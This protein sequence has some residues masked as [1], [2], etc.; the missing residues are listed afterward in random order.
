M[1]KTRKDLLEGDDDLSLRVN[2]KFAEKY[3]QKKRHEELSRAK[4]L[5]LLDDDESTSEEEDEE[6][7][8]LTAQVDNKI[9]ETLHMIKKKDPKI[10][11]KEISFFTDEDFENRPNADVKKEKPLKY[12][13]Y[14][15]ETLLE[16]G[17]EALESD[18]EKPS[19]REETYVE[20]QA[21]LKQEFLKAFDSADVSENEHGTENGEPKKKKKDKKKKSKRGKDGDADDG[22][23]LRVRS[24]TKEEMEREDEDFSE[25]IKKE[26]IKAKKEAV[27]EMQ[28]LQRYFEDEAGLDD[29]EKFL[30]DYILN[31]GWV[32]RNDPTRD[33]FEEDGEEVDD[34]ED[35]T[36]LEATDE[37]EASYNFRFQ[38]EGGDQIIGHSRNLEG[39]VRKKDDK[40]QKARLERE[41]RKQE[42]KARKDEELKRLKN[43]KKKEIAEKIKKIQEIT[44]NSSVGLDAVDIEGDFDPAEHDA[45]MS[46]MFDDSYYDQDDDGKPAFDDDDDILTEQDLS[47]IGAL[48]GKK[49]PASTAAVQEQPES[50]EDYFVCDG[51]QC[52]LLPIEE[53]FDCR[54]CEDYCLCPTCKA[55]NKHSHKMKRIK[56]SAPT[57]SMSDYLDEYYK[58][59]YEDIIG[60]LPVR[61]KYQ[62]VAANHYGL[63]DEELL[64]LDDKQLNQ[65]VPLKKLAP[66][67]EDQGKVASALLRK[68]KAALLSVDES[69]QG[70][71]T[72][73][74]HS[75]HEAEGSS[76]HEK[77]HKKNR[78]DANT[79]PQ[80]TGK[81]FKDPNMRMTPMGVT[82]SR[83]E[84]YGAA[85]KQVMRESKRDKYRKK[86]QNGGRC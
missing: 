59:D 30:R 62:K 63:T 64:A 39:S 6:G 13:D 44:G 66:Y 29:N 51:C 33:G 82:E 61:F 57:M 1:G 45:K 8:L 69:A 83:F 80:N 47:T 19:K 52:Q 43:L 2:K 25:F 9:F 84:A 49:P 36:H 53:R 58:L 48:K 37:F 18:D 11:N 81:M 15:R 75:K 72:S 23:L 28:T 78:H 74:K 67:R 32:D 10:Y 76:R 68:R 35:E 71:Q 31:K 60:D 34:S 17:A 5:G 4:D 3:E 85:A 21:R 40:R 22:E 7:E 38:E 79:T 24:K 42:E 14:V 70:E 65:H 55:E 73:S 77:K 12:K 41:Q 26:N 50:Y 16:G 56:A 46:E 86:N 20:E 54:E 27:S